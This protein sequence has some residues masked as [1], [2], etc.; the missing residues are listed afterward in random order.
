MLKKQIAK[1]LILNLLLT[2]LFSSFFTFIAISLL[3]EDKTGSIEGNSGLIIIVLAGTLW[4]LILTLSSLTVLFNLDEKVRHNKLL[5]ILT[6]FFLPILVTTIV[7]I[8][9]GSDFKD[10]WQPFSIMTLSFMV[11]HIYFFVKFS[12]T[13]FN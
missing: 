5:C 10:M 2:F 3:Y 11:T 9:S 8:F 7:F 13:H 6:F 12:K 4:N 1:R